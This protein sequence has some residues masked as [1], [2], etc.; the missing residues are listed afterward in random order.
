MLPSVGYQ[1]SLKRVCFLSST[2]SIYTLTPDVRLDP[3]PYHMYQVRIVY[4]ADMTQDTYRSQFL[5][6]VLKANKINRR[7]DDSL[8]DSTYRTWLPRQE[9]R[10]QVRKS[11]SW[12]NLR[13]LQSFL[14]TIC[15]C[16]SLGVGRVNAQF[17]LSSKERQRTDPYS[18]SEEPKLTC[19]ELLS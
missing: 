3:T 8:R 6:I 7:F 11:P 4:C 14:L 12:L 1:S 18:V 19:E 13:Y 5:V 9:S 17:G 16:G 10:G 15:S 2:N